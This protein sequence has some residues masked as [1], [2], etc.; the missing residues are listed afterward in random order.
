MICSSF[1]TA[2]PCFHF[3]NENFAP[4]NVQFG[5]DLFSKASLNH[6]FSRM[7]MA[8]LEL[9]V[10]ER[11]IGIPYTIFTCM[12]AKH[13]TDVVSIEWR[14]LSH[15]QSHNGALRRNF[16]KQNSTYPI[17]SPDLTAP[18]CF[19]FQVKERIL[20]P[21]VQNVLKIAQHWSSKREAFKKLF[22]KKVV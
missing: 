19:R 1:S 16:W 2:Q 8:M 10:V 4:W 22:F 17:H 6:S 11:D 20:A 7:K 9:L 5:I 21:V 15:S 12:F 14:C 13:G 3:H 18:N